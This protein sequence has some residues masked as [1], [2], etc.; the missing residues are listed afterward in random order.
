MTVICIM[1]DSCNIKLSDYKN[2]IDYISRYQIAYNKILS[3]IGDNSAWIL[4][5]TIELT[6][7]GNF[8][9]HLSKK[10]LA[11]VI[12]IET[13]WREEITS[14]SD[15]VFRVIIYMEINIG[16]ERDMVSST[17]ITLVMGAQQERAVC[18]TCTNQECIN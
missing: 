4:K 14:L 16:N 13:E 11:L 15:T 17:L 6:L 8:F 3:L 12:T 5:K 7:Q 2:I 9:K 10:Y 18:G 1:C